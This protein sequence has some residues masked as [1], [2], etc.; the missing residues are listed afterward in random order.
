MAVPFSTRIP[1]VK[2][3][4]LEFSKAFP[5]KL[6]LSMSINLPS[7]TEYGFVLFVKS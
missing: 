1:Q 4:L 3:S 6:S 2:H 7:P 5:I